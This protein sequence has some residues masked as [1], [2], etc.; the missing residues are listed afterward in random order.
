MKNNAHFNT[1][2]IDTFIRVIS[3]NRILLNITLFISIF[4]SIRNVEIYLKMKK[5][6][7]SNNNILYK[8]FNIEPYEV[9][10]NDIRNPSCSKTCD[11]GD[12]EAK[13]T[14]KFNVEINSFKHMFCDVYNAIEIDVS[15]LDFSKVID[16]SYM[17]DGC[18]NLEKIN[19]GNANTAQ[20]TNMIAMFQRCEKLISFDLSKFITSKVTNMGYMFS[21]CSSLEYLN[22]KNFDTSRVENMEVM[23]QSCSKLTSL[24]LS[25]FDTSKV[26]NTRF[27]FY[28]CKNLKYLNLS[29]FDISK[30]TSMEQMFYNCNSLIFL[31]LRSFKGKNLNKLNAFKLISPY[32]FIVL[33][34]KMPKIISKK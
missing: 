22:I 30:V 15:N 9:L 11:L 5:I 27:M 7:S 25:N 21:L 14:L 18:E 20:V 12:G 6:S 23:F 19:F 3:F 33:K 10:V 29:N 26:N 31:N 24:D 32:V 4:S 28:D 2:K 17:F 16:T 8:G 1:Q 34:T 13:I